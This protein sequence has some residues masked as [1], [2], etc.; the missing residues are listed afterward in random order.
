MNNVYRIKL[1]SPIL[2]HG[3]TIETTCSEKYV[4][5]V[6]KLMMDLAR[7]INETEGVKTK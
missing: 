7:E 3:L 1:E 4:V 2:R 6:S 5:K